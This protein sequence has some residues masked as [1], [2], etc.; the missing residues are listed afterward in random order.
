MIMRNR[1][2][3]FT[4]LLA[5]TIFFSC[6]NISDKKIRIAYANWAEGI[7]VTY[8]AKEIL[9]EQG[10]RIELLNADI[11]PIFTSL[12]RGK[13]DVFMDSWLP[14]THADYFRKYNDELEILGQIYDSARI[15]L[16]VPEYVPV[17]TIEELDGHTG[18][19]SGEIVGIDAGTGIMK[20]TEKA[21][22]EYGLDYRL[23]ILSLIHI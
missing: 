15:G 12:A 11:A 21:I 23:M 3:F 4:V 7:A 17:H 9:S 8:L 5:V 6:G 10:Y 18:R 19:F 13:T 20:C 14:V 1:T 22:P 16:V 2:I